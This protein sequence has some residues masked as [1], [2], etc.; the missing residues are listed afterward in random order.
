MQ[1]ET[2]E[3]L[4]A[5]LE[6]GLEELKHW[7]LKLA[8]SEH[9]YRRSKAKAWAMVDKVTSDGTKK[10]AAEIEAGVDEM[11]ADLRM[12]RDQAEY[13]RQAS[14]EAVRSRRQQLSAWQSLA[15]AERAEAEFVRTA[16]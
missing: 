5:S 8:Q 9:A 7:A 1:R 11:V 16:P 4:C 2:M 3:I 14:L 6:E 12:A 15:A 13:M 10:L